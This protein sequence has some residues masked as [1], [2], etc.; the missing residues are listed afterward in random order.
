[1]NHWTRHKRLIVSTLY[2][3]FSIWVFCYLIFYNQLDIY[4]RYLMIAQ[5]SVQE[6]VV[7]AKKEL[8]MVHAPRK[9]ALVSIR[10]FPMVLARINEIAHNNE[11]NI[12][13]LIVD[14]SGS[15]VKFN[16]DFITDY[17]SLLHFVLEL[18][19]LDIMVEDFQ[20]HPHDAGSIPP[21]HVV[22]LAVIPKNDAEPIAGTRLDA[23]KNQ[24]FAK[25]KRN[26]FQRFSYDKTL[27]M[28]YPA[29]DLT[30]TYQ[31]TAIGF[32]QD[33]KPY[34][35]IDRWFYQVGDHLDG[36]ELVKIDEERVYLQKRD[37][38][39]ITEYI[40]NWREARQGTTGVP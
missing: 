19:S 39:G 36:Y 3:L 5:N 26:P 25:G 24:V 37:R 35:M 17:F 6:D 29:I 12:K 7:R 1:M 18:E 40:I 27:K 23:L 8:Q 22:A 30:D 38:N 9:D 14:D 15:T 32:N 20:L 4:K 28:V 31:L 21:R 13:N 10:Y 33:N 34:A 16:M 2:M 11:I